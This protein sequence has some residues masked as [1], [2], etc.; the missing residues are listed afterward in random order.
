MLRSS[1]E[2]RHRSVVD[3]VGHVLTL[4]TDVGAWHGLTTVLQVRLTPYERGS[5][6]AAALD[7][8][9]DDEMFRIVETVVPT[10]LAGVPMTPWLDLEGEARW[11]A[12]HASPRELRA[13]LATCFV[14]LPAKEQSTFLSAAQRRVAA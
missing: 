9:E 2:P 11:W 1:L 7:A 13:Y 12:D 4:E 6:A 14:R 5:L 3:M 8:T 10:R